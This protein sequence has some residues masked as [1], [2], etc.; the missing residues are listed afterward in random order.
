[1]LQLLSSSFAS[2]AMACSTTHLQ[3]SFGYLIER[4]A[5]MDINLPRALSRTPEVPTNWQY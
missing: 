5:T 1:M 2:A 4:A 3:G